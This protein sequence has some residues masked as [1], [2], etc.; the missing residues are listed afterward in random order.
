MRSI[1]GA[2][3]C[4]LLAGLALLAMPCVAFATPPAYDPKID[5]LDFSS[6]ITNPFL[7][8][9]PGRQFTYRS[10]DGTER[11]EIEVQHD[12]KLILGVLTTVV[13]D[14]VYT[15][16]VKS[17]DTYDWYAQ[18]KDGTVWYFGEDTKTLD[19]QGNVIS[20]EGSWEAGQGGAKPGIAMLGE[21]EVGES[22]RQEF[23]PGVAEDFA[24]IVGDNE[25][26]SVP[27]GVFG[28]CVATAEWT[29]LAPGPKEHKFYARGVGLVLEIDRKERLELVDVKH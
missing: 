6:S 3:R 27:Y 10:T 2:R 13:H 17:E 16:G 19:A 14:V 15:D 18:H 22:Y 4:A 1:P 9:P 23:L 26:I 5:P 28:S 25:L 8:F 21:I 24:K 11:I 7:P 20:T 12:T 29:P